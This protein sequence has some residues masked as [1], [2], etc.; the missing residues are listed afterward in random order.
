MNLGGLK[1]YDFRANE[2]FSNNFYEYNGTVSLN[3]N[4]LIK[5]SS[6]RDQGYNIYLLG[7]YGMM[8]YSSYRTELDGTPISGGD[9]GYAGIGRANTI[10]VGAGVRVNIVDKLNF[11]GEFTT[12]ISNNDDL[13]TKIENGDNDSY[14][15]FSLGLSYDLLGSSSGNSRH[16]KSLRWGRF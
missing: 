12:H 7:G 5:L 10:I 3:I 1:G 2:Q 14:Y 13:D 11:L 6:Y 16:R 4:H 15:Y 8:R 9:I